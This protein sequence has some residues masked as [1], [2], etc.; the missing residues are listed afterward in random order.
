[1]TLKTQYLHAHKF[2][3]K[4]SFMDPTINFGIDEKSLQNSECFTLR[5]I[6]VTWDASKLA[7]KKTV[8][9]K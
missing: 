6:A 1:M 7:E 2:F 8:M 3:P 9:P 5:I 4:H